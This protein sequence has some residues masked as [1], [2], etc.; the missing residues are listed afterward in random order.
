MENLHPLA[1][2]SLRYP[3]PTGQDHDRPV[4][5]EMRLIRQTHSLV[6]LG[7]SDVAPYVVSFIDSFFLISFCIMDIGFLSDFWQ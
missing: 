3:R 2:P 5:L 1:R 6:Y 7:W 4:F